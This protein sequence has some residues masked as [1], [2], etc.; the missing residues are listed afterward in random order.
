MK[1]GIKRQTKK[2]KSN[3]D[4]RQKKNKQQKRQTKRLNFA[5]INEKKG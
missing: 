2:I 3:S 1:K 4:K 5:S